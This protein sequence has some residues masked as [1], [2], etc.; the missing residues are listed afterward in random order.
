MYLEFLRIV[1]AKRP[2]FFIAENV[3][4]ILSLDSG[5]AFA[6][7]LRDFGEIGYSI[8]HAV[9]NAADYG[10]PQR[11]E[12]VLF[13]GRWRDE[14]FGPEFPPPRTHAPLELYELSGLKKWV[15]IGEALADVPCPD[16]PHDLQNHEYTKYKL[17]FNGYLGHRR[18]DPELPCPTITARGDDNGGVVIHHHPSNKRRLSAREAALL[19]SFPIDYKFYGTK[20]SIYR[21]VA[22]AV[23]P[24]LAFKMAEIFAPIGP[25]ASLTTALGSILPRWYSAADDSAAKTV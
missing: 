9:L 7:I 14:E 12:R 13:L 25:G 16:G 8:K 6:Q 20:T 24:L 11:R 4:G 23:P 19:Q 1:E 22:N 5:K 21:Q 17:R 2:R 15:S 3:K 18:I 10:V